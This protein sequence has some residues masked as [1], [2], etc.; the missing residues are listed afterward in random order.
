MRRAYEVDRPEIRHPDTDLGALQAALVTVLGV[1]AGAAWAVPAAVVGAFARRRR[2]GAV[3]YVLLALL[4]SAAGSHAWSSAAPRHLGP[5]TGWAEL[6][7][8]PSPVGF[9]AKAT[10]RIGGERFD[11][12]LFGA[13][14]AALADRQAGEWAWVS[15][16]RRPNRGAIR[17]A[18]IRHVVGRFDIDVVGDVVPGNAI[19]RASNRVRSALRRSAEA[20]MSP[21]DAALFSGLV[22][23]DDSRQPGWLVSDFRASGLSHLTAVSGQNVAYVLAAAIPL[24]RRLRPGWRWAATVGLIG[25]FM[26]LTRFEPSVLRAGVMAMLSATAFVLGR[27]MH[28]VRSVSIAV[29]LLTLLDPMLVWSVGFWLSVGATL[30]VAVAGPW[31]AQRLPGPLWLRLAAGVTLGAQT[32]V[33]LPSLLVFHRLAIISL[34]ANLAAV[35]V[36]GFVMLYGLPAGLFAAALPAALARVAMAPVVVGTRW[37]AT[38]ASVASALEPSGGWE[39]IAWVGAV[40]ALVVIVVRHSRRATEGV[41]I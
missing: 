5:Y 24:L 4:A 6:V 19:D 33:A 31:W 35:P 10:V 14:R 41:P 17:R 32:G 20:A 29:V 21:A 8:D 28:P 26:A 37:V 34:P 13:D 9:G 30:G 1:W 3:A 7:K 18:L 2:R 36:A 23:G 39:V 16:T 38:V 15:G 22:I 11:T 12:W 27:S 40:G 25:W